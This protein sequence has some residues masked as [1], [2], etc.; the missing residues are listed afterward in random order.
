MQELKSIFESIDQMMKSCEMDYNELKSRIIDEKF[1]SNYD[2]QRI[3]NSF[4]FNYLKIQDKIGAKLFKGVLYG[5]KEIEDFSLPMIDVLHLLEKLAL[6]ENTEDW[7]RL[8]EIR[9]ALSHEYPLDI[10]ERI[11]NI[12]LALQGYE[13]IKRIYGR[14]KELCVSKGLV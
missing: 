11:E 9:N 13:M 7:D 1:F 4:L 8:R 5:L 3:V 6:L 14:L 12:G 2:E 10:K